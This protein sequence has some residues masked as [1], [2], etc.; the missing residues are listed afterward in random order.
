MGS[1]LKIAAAVLAV[2]IGFELHTNG[3]N[4]AFGGIFA[5]ANSSEPEDTRSTVQRAG[6]SASRAHQESDD[7][8]QRMLGE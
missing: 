7:R 2:W 1:A 3:V 5:S 4:G 6:S 8:R